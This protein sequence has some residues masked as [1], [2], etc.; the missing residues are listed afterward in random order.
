MSI[1]FGAS[2]SSAEVRFANM[3]HL[4]RETGWTLDY[5][6]SLDLLTFNKVLA[7]FEAEDKARAH[8]QRRQ[9]N[10]GKRAKG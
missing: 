10:R 9:Q 8:L 6:E 4:A 7:T 2:L 1:A 5:M 3:V